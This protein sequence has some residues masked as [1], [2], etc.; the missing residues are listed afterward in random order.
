M[1]KDRKEYHKEWYRKNRARVLEQGKKRVKEHYEEYKTR[2]RAVILKHQEYILDYKKDKGCS[3]CGYKEY[4][5]ILQF[6]HKDRKQKDFTIGKKFGKN[7]E[8]IKREMDKCILLCP[9]C[10][11]WL[12]FKETKGQV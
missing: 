12:H 9:N 11:S 8:V 5:E 7:I 10:H 4:P 3:I 6:H 1:E 2:K